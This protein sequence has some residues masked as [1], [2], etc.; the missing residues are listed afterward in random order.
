MTDPQKTDQ[1]AADKAAADKAAADKADK[2]QKTKAL[3]AAEMKGNV[4]I[5]RKPNGTVIH[6]ALAE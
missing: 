2:A 4:L 6:N 5:R 1:A 3:P